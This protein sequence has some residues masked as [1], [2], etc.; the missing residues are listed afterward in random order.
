MGQLQKDAH[1]HPV[2]TRS[3]LR[4]LLITTTARL[5]PFMIKV[6]ENAYIGGITEVTNAIKKQIN[7]FVAN[8]GW[9][10]ADLRTTIRAIRHPT[11]VVGTRKRVELRRRATSNDSCAWRTY[12]RPRSTCRAAW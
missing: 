10:D 8:G 9:K 3:Q 2:M 12:T 1:F 4:C 7:T 11:V 6:M 5:K